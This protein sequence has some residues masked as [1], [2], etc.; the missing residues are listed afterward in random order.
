M[1]LPFLDTCS[2]LKCNDLSIFDKFIISSMSLIEL[3]NIKTSRNKDDNIKAKA[4]DVVR[5]LDNNTNNYEI[6]VVTQECYDELSKQ[7]LEVTNDNLIITCAYLYHNNVNDVSFYSEDIL[8]RFIA[9]N[10]FKLNVNSLV[11]NKS[12]EIYKGYKKIKGNSEVI[13]EYMNN[14]DFS[15]WHTNEYL[16]IEN[17]DDNKTTEM[18]FDGSK[19]VNLKLPP[20]NYIKAKNSLQRCALDLL[21]NKDITTVAILGGYGS[22]KTMLSIQMAL[23][24]V[25]EKG[26]QGKILGIRECVGEGKEIGYL[27]GTFEDKTGKFFKPI[28]QQLQGGEFELES[29]ISKGV[30]ETN[31][32]FYLKGT[33]Y[34]DTIIVVDEA[35]DLSESQIKLIGTRLGQNSKIYFAGD[36]KQSY[37]NNTSSNALIRMC[38]ELKGNSMFGCIVLEEDVRSETSKLFADLFS[39]KD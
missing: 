16:I 8:C 5:W 10:F 34:N 22:G 20:S 37:L 32:P 21:L 35:E 11:E 14:I 4:R 29:L 18:R 27:K 28:E 33:T 13:N 38:K 7:N 30:L 39:E 24:N 6:V 23:Y 25:K 9:N 1:A 2:L 36:Y 12:D 31:I 17:S 26:S 15:E 19:F 3:E